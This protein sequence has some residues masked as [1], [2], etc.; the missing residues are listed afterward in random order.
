MRR[1][2]SEVAQG[3]GG[4]WPRRQATAEA[5]VDTAETQVVTVATAG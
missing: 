1:S 3:R 4:S 5:S 2:A